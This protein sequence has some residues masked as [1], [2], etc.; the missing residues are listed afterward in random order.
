M[1][2]P[3][4]ARQWNP[5]LI[6]TRALLFKTGSTLLALGSSCIIGRLA[7]LY[8]LTLVCI[9]AVNVISRLVPE[10]SNG[11]SELGLVDGLRLIKAGVMLYASSLVL[12]VLM[13]GFSYGFLCIM[14]GSMLLTCRASEGACKQLAAPVATVGVPLSRMAGQ[15]Q[16]VMDSQ[17][18]DMFKRRGGG[19]VAEEIS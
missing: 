1:A 19:T 17:T 3:A 13:V 4:L 12:S 8:P 9:E 11:R 7:L 10:E 16:R 14:G 5:I 15:V 18:M 2:Q 6:D